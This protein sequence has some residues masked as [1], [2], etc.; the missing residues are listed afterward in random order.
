M[1]FVNLPLLVASALVFTSVVSGLVSARF[2]FSF[3]LVFLIAGILAGEDGPGGL[4][5]E[6]FQ[7]SFWVGN[8]ALAVILLDGG[9]R[10]S[11]ESFRAGLRPALLLA[12]VGVGI[13]ALITGLA[14]TV[15]LDFD[16]KLGVLLGSIVG[17]T[18]A[19]AVFALLKKSGVTLNERVETTLEIESGMNDPMAVYLTLTMIGLVLAS[20][21][22]GAGELAGAL[23]QL[24]LQFG[25]GAAAGVTAGLLL[26]ITLHKLPAADPGINALLIASFGLIVFAATGWAGGSGFLAV[27]LLGMVLSRRVSGRAAAPR[28]ENALAAMDGFAW[29]SQASM[30]LLLGL[31]VTPS[32]VMEIAAPAVG[33]AA[34]LMLIARP[35]AVWICL[36]PFRFRPKE[37]VFISWV[38][39]RGAVPI[40]LA[41][42]PLIAGV[43]NAT[44]LFNV[45]FVVVLM[46]LMLQGAT[47][48]ISAR[49]LGVALPDPAD[50]RG[51]R[52]V[53]GDFVLD[54]S[55]PVKSLCEFYDLPEPPDSDAPL[56]TWLTS[57]LGRTPIVGDH[58]Q[59]GAAT[60]VIRGM[61]GGEVSHVGMKFP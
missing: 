22:P 12:T 26:A 35:L 27:Y 41:V 7:L 43:S 14:A 5:F 29:L 11:F 61:S 3:L 8:I 51:S 17:S 9:L 28:V 59:L 58:V 42:F 53:F 47:I 60:L 15:L 44:L 33:I 40:V 21:Q 23:G 52:V 1:D 19:A 45:A 6:D 18:D 36:L 4:R 32:E 25:L 24:G 39:L 56:G 57:V 54:A 2:G 49:L 13:T 38:G 16:W 46:S 31:L 34:V 50:E 10:T 37:V 30:F 48:G 20:A 55:T